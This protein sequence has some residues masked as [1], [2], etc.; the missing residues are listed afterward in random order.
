MKKC[1]VGM[2]L[3]LVVISLAIG[4][5]SSLRFD[6]IPN[7]PMVRESTSFI[8]WFTPDYDIHW[9]VNNVPAGIGQKIEY[10]FPSMGTYAIVM[11]VFRESRLIYMEGRMVQT[12]YSPPGY[13]PSPPKTVSM[14]IVSTLSPPQFDVMPHF[15]TVGEPT[16]FISWFTP[17]YDIHWSV[18][19][20]SAGV[21]QIIEYVFPS[22][23][24]YSVVM[25][26]FQGPN[27]IYTEER[28]VQTQYSPPGY[29]PSPPEIPYV[30]PETPYVPPET[31]YVPPETPYIP[32]EIPDV[33]LGGF[34][35]TSLVGLLFLILG[36][37]LLL[38]E[39]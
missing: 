11:E 17:G 2:V 12:Q 13:N 19:N 8:S 29:N 24:T 36:A 28:A 4:A 39:Q 3:L 23:E 9:S 1:L 16:S 6:V 21:G 18:N 35:P 7:L 5:Q 15:P 20:V 26:V 30:P 33:D 38:Q 34:S 22:I 25:E 10:T 31:P 37:F 27:L 14:T 32:P